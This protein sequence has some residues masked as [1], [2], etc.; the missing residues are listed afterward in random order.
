MH[1]REHTS[2][3]KMK[4]KSSRQGQTAREIERALKSLGLTTDE[5]HWPM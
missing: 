5:P 2:E 4:Q 3:E 1:D